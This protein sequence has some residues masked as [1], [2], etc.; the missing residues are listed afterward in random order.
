[1][2]FL[3]KNQCLLFQKTCYGQGIVLS[4]SVK[5]RRR[6]RRF[7]VVYR[8]RNWPAYDAGLKQRKATRNDS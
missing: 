5:P 1:M 8:V 7:K 4:P 2:T 6:R 3:P